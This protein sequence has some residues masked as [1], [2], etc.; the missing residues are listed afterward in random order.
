M[1]LA[2]AGDLS[3]AYASNSARHRRW[4]RR[5]YQR[6]PGCKVDAI[7]STVSQQDSRA[8]DWQRM[9]DLL[10]LLT[11]DSQP[12]S[13]FSPHAVEFEREG[14]K[15]KA[16]QRYGDSQLLS[17][18]LSESM[19]KKLADQKKKVMTAPTDVAKEEAPKTDGRGGEA[20]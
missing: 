18:K 16:T 19:D 9:E 2:T 8:G 5:H 7:P 1:D 13:Q 15:D 12:V 20:G 6:V 4:R 14:S 10:T 11:P 17:E 3:S